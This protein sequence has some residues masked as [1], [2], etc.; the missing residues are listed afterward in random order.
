MQRVS[1]KRNDVTRSVA[2]RVEARLAGM[3]GRLSIAACAA[4]ALGVPAHAADPIKV[5]LLEPISKLLVVGDG[6]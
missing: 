5:G 2:S 4:L 6:L 1:S 3:I